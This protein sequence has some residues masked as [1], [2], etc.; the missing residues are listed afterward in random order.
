MRV[1]PNTIRLNRAVALIVGELVCAALAAPGTL[2]AGTTTVF[3]D[4]SQTTNFVASGTTSDTLSSQGYVFMLT[5]DKLFTGGVGLTNPIG[6]TLR[7]SWP[8]GLEAQAVTAGPAPG[9]AQIVIQRQDG[10]PFAIESFTARLL[11]NTAGAGGSI[12]IMPLLNGVDGLPDPAAFD[13]TGYAG[14][15]FTYAPANLA[16]FDTYNLSLYVDF[17]LTAITLVDPRTPPSLDVSRAG[18]TTV[19]LRWPAIAADYTLEFTTG[20]PAQAWLPA[21]HP[22]TTNGDIC[23]VPIDAIGP[24]RFYRLKK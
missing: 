9:G 7:V 18:P 11:A 13:A 21:T 20:M 1:T 22:V 16:G 24:G 3:F 12:E 19:E 10:Q 23:T 2:H 6:R 4:P 14:S 17:A 15:Q 8:T 5:R